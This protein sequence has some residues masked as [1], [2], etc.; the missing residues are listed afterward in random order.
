MVE[1]G[2]ILQ[3]ILGKRVDRGAETK[4]VKENI[5][6]TVDGRYMVWGRHE[7]AT[8]FVTIS[9]LLSILFSM[10]ITDHSLNEK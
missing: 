5:E 7:K 8:L 2:R 6:E 3:N 4:S 10:G 9:A 1:I